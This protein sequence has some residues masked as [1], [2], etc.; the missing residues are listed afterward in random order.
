M[1]KPPDILKVNLIF[2]GKSIVLLCSNKKIP[3]YL[4]VPN[5]TTRKG[6]MISFKCPLKYSCL[7]S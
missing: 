5:T 1:K 7:R 3:Q 2:S 6:H 4:F